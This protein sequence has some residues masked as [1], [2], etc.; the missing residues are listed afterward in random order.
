MMGLIFCGAAE[1]WN[2]GRMS[3]IHK[4]T[5]TPTKLE[6]LSGWL[7]SRPRYR[8]SGGVPA[9]VKAGGFR[10]DDP[11]G[12]VGIE[13]MVVTDTAGGQPVAYHVPLTYRGK[14]LDGAGGALIG[15][16]EHARPDGAYAGGL[17]CQARARRVLGGRRARRHAA[18]HRRGRRRAAE[19]PRAARP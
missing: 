19:R 1:G 2:A 14:P 12:A 17:A 5:L 4:T 8:G 18:H 16:T 15:T 9:L 11:Q 13:L 10:L 6:L 3:I 7:P